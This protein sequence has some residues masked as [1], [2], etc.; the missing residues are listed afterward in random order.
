MAVTYNGQSVSLAESAELRA[1]TEIY[2]E[3]KGKDAAEFRLTE[4]GQE[5]PKGRF[6]TRVKGDVWMLQKKTE[7][8]DTWKSY[9][10]LD[11]AGVFVE[12]LNATQSELLE[13]MYQYLKEIREVLEW[14]VEG[15]HEHE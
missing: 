11:S 9:I 13:A 14:A 6:R 2:W 1:A 3:V 7:A 5:D 8:P 15:Q 12:P 4:E 10:T